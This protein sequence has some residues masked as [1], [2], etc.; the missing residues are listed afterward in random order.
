MRIIHWQTE[1]AQKASAYRD[2][3]WDIYSGSHF[4]AMDLILESII[5]L[6]AKKNDCTDKPWMDKVRNR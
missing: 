6:Q 2:D 3:V 4:Q 5:V 1:T